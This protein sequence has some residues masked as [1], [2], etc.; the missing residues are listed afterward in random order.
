MKRV[1]AGYPVAA[2][3]QRFFPGTRA[4]AERTYAGG[5][6]ETKQLYTGVIKNANETFHSNKLTRKLYPLTVFVT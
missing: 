3:F 1:H 6:R 4:E 2:D 5:S